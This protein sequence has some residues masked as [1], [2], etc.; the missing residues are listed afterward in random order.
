MKLY[1]LMQASVSLIACAAMTNVATAQEASSAAVSAE[2]QAPVSDAEIIVTGSRIEGNSTFKAPTPVTSLSQDQLVASAPAT[3]ADGLKILPA[4]VPTGGPSAGGGTAN[5]G[6]NFLNMRGLGTA[7]TLVLVNGMRFVPA[8]PS[9]LIDT[10]LVPQG[11]VSHVDVVTGGASAAY[12]SDAVAG[13]ANFVLDTKLKG[14]KLDTYYGVSQ[15]GDNQE[16]KFQLSGGFQAMDGRLRVVASGEHYD[17]K[18]VPGN[19]R[20]FRR[21]AANQIR[22]PAAPANFIR[23]EDVRTPFTLGGLVVVGGGGTSANNNLISGLKFE[24]G[25]GTTA[26]DYGRN[27]TTIRATSGTQDGG[28]GYSVSVG[29]E[30]IRPLRRDALF[31]HSELDVLDNV[32]LI[33]EGTYGK[34]TSVFENSPTVATVT[35]Q[36][37]NPFLAAADPALVNRM[38]ALGVTNLRLNR[39]ILE[40][41]ATLTTNDNETVRGLFGFKAELLGLNWNASYQYGRND[42]HSETNNNLLTA[43]LNRAVNA[44]RSGNQVVCADTLSGNQA[45]RDAAAGCVA[46]NPFGFESPS[47]SALDFVM[48]TSVFDTRTTQ[49]VVDGTV[50]GSLFELPAGPVQFAAGYEWRKLSATTVADD[51]SIAG[52]YRLVNQQNFA[53]SYSINEFFGELQLPIFK[54]SALGRSFDVNLAARHTNYSTSGG[55]DTWKAGFSWQLTDWLRL[56]GTRSRDIRAPNLEELY[57]TGRQNNITVIDSLTQKTY[58]AVPNQTFGNLALNPEKANTLVLGAVFEP[59]SNLNLAVD[60]YSIKINDAIRSIGGAQAVEQCNLSN[61][62]SSICSFVTR[63]PS[64]QAV[65]KTL[66]APFNLTRQE[67]SGV[68]FEARWRLGLG[69]DSKVTMRLLGSYVHKNIVF[70]PLIANPVNDVGNLISQSIGQ[71]TSQPRWRVTGTVNFDKGPFAA[72][73]Q[74]RYIGAFT[75]DKT[76]TLGVDTDFNYVS[77]QVYVDAQLSVKVPFMDHDQEF[78]LN[79]QNLL[80]KQPPYAPLPTGA[81]PLPTQPVLYDQIGRMFRVGLRARF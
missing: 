12:G 8:G 28:D 70:S 16:F 32:T 29:Q 72:F 79:V 54:D 73:V 38:T 52:A 14:L 44:V 63:D 10:N 2:E 37:A 22:D 65:V 67:T 41:G 6:Q 4:I 81:T 45:T 47:A 80:D 58:T 40:R 15:R 78:Y 36:R 75:W 62:T 25:G 33:A 68:D 64:T 49:H 24:Q 46:F 23:A 3:I 27:A 13:V 55:V 5:G 42:N 74:T 61:Q 77:P 20:D 31:M 18:G 57:A 48:G 69:S 9:G 51:L 66:T 39:L 21:K 50:S 60:Y 35:I 76:R 7:R 1:P 56:R 53:G 19:A 26:Y 34:T 43:N 59:T 71:A 11:L 30:I 17:N